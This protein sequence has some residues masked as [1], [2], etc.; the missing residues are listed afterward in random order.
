[1]LIQCT[2]KLLNE[3]KI[4]PL[5]YSDEDPLE[6]DIAIVNNELKWYCV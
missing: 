3:L 6:F 5:P 4:D 2:R 1:M